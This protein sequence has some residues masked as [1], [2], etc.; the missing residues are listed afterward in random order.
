MGF[1]RLGSLPAR[2]PRTAAI[3]ICGVLGLILPA[4]FGY[5]TSFREPSVHDEFSYLLSGDTFAHGRLA[6]P[7]P[8][9]TR[10]F[11]AEHVLLVPT[12]GS[13]Y[14]PG[15]GVALA[16]GQVIFGH[17]MWGVWL[18]CGLFAASLC[19]ML[20][21]WTTKSVAFVVTLFAIVSLGISTYWAQT[22][23]GGMMAASGGALLFG[24]L[25][26]TLR[27]PTVLPGMLMG[28]GTVILANTRPF[29]GVVTCVPVAVVIVWWLLKDTRLSFPAKL[30]RW[31]VPFA[32]PLVVGGAGM[33][34]HNQAATGNWLRP[35]YSVYDKQYFRRSIFIFSGP[36]EPEL[37]PLDRLAPFFNRDGGRDPYRGMG[38]VRKAGENFVYRL[39]TIFLSALGN[40]RVKP[41]RLEHYI[42]LWI[43]AIA[44][45]SL[46]SRWI[47]LCL[48]TTILVAAASSIVRYEHTHYTAPVVALILAI[49][50]DAIRR[51]S[52]LRI[53]GRRVVTA[54]LLLTLVGTYGV[55]ISIQPILDVQL[56]GRPKGRAQEAVAGVFP[57]TSR[58]DLMATLQSQTGDHLVF[59]RYDPNYT[60]HDEWAY[61]A[62]DM[63]SSPIII[64]HDL[65]EAEN[66]E[67]I[68]MYPDRQLWWAS[69]SVAGKSLRPYSERPDD[70]PAGAAATVE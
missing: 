22:Y 62:A 59:I 43:L 46:R 5:L 18:S 10:F 63:N 57:L 40:V 49:M 35:P 55:A 65:G 47:W 19:W 8:R 7:S 11:E 26:R 44:A 45:A 38:A 61:N 1:A 24:G 3:A 33:A 39:P 25:R 58:A 54:G 52:L 9:L 34:M 15:Q 66:R 20:Q 48:I 17:P 60:V 27:F 37:K 42:V 28:T 6:N 13:K 53:G 36:R 30:G 41:E 21:S 12:Y 68:A 16:A 50:A 67:L 51:Y 32:V 70:S 69:V 64:A 2:L 14:P 29:E 56:R 31:L 4:G 23:W